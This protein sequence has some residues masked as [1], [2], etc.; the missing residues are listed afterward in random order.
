MN[1]LSIE[2]MQYLTE[3]LKSMGIDGILKNDDVIIVGCGIL[4]AGIDLAAER[5]S[6]N[7]KVFTPDNLKELAD[8]VNVPL[9]DVLNLVDRFS[10]QPHRSVRDDFEKLCIAA[11]NEYLASDELGIGLKSSSLLNRDN[12]PFYQRAADKG[13][14]KRKQWFQNK[15]RI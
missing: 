12:R 2:G 3:K 10:L 13:G 9:D 6:S 8:T 1:E 11:N 5:L 4:V 15:G 7:Y 14:N